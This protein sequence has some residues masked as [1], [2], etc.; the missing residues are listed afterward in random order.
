MKQVLHVAAT[1]LLSFLRTSFLFMHFK[2]DFSDNMALTRKG[3]NN[4]VKSLKVVSKEEKLS[5]RSYQVRKGLGYF[6]VAS[7]RPNKKRRELQELAVNSLW[8]FLVSACSHT[9][10]NK[11]FSGSVQMI[12]ELLSW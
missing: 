11:A 9:P 7:E 3:K 5:I 10:R 8:P 12:P 4:M 2:I 6:S 1:K